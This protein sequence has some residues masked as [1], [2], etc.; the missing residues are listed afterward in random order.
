MGIGH[1]VSTVHVIDFSLSKE[2]RSLDTHLHI[3]LHQGMKCG[4]TRSVLFASNNSHTGCELGRWDNL[5]SLAY[6]LIYF[7]CGGLPWEGLVNSN[8]IAQYKLESSTEDLCNGLPV[9]YA[10][11][12]SYSQ[13]LPFDAKPDY[14]YISRLFSESVPHEGTHPVFDWDSG[15]AHI[16][17][18][19]T[20]P[21]PP[22]IASRMHKSRAAPIRRTG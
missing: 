2:F 7:L 16:N 14:D 12:L 19:Y 3:P 17:T 10:T 22:M 18:L 6:V 15:L 9:K 4:L 5:E 1:Q 11:L 20:N 8:L 21:P 13:M